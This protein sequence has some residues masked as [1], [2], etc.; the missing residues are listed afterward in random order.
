MYEGVLK[1][2]REYKKY[3]GKGQADIERDIEALRA[4]KMSSLEE[5]RALVYDVRDQIDHIYAPLFVVQATNDDVIDTD[6][7]NVIYANTESEEKYI[8]WYEQSG[9][10]ITL[11]PEKVK[12]HED[13][14]KFLESLDW[15]E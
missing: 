5:L 14:L 4:Q 12:L 8:K 7:A 3:E 2:A 10:V 11:G 6:S 1:Y 13:I 15:N 9:H